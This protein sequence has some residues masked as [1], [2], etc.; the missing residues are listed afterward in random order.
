MHK[1]ALIV[2]CLAPGLLFAAK[3]KKPPPAPAAP[4]PAEILDVSAVRDRLIVVTD[5]KGHYVA[6]PPDLLLKDE[7]WRGRFF[8]SPD[9]K[10][11]AS[12]SYDR[13]VRLWQL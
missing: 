7:V 4:D 5:G 8:Y 2:L 6:T 11:L 1:L 12:G 10:T 3:G 9:G 13:T